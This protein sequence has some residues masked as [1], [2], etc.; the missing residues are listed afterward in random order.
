M[1]QN[2]CDCTTLY[3]AVG[4]SLYTLFTRPFL[5]V[6]V[7]LACKTKYNARACKSTS[8][9]LLKT[10]DFQHKAFIYP[11]SKIAKLQRKDSAWL[12]SQ[13]PFSVDWVWVR[14]NRIKQLSD[15]QPSV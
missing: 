1:S 5:F 8:I 3:S 2:K 6:E 4:H 14:D 10:C 13:D 7:G 15:L 12:L 11:S 9:V